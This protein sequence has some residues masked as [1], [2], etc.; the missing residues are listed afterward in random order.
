MDQFCT[1]VNAVS[2]DLQRIARPAQGPQASIEW[3]AFPVIAIFLLKP[4]FDGFMAEA[5]RDHYAIVRKALKT[6]WSKFFA[7]N[8]KLRVAVI[9]SSGERKPRYS[10]VFAIYTFTDTGRL[11]KLLLREDCREDE[12]TESIDAFLD[13]LESYHC[14][15]IQAKQ[16]IDIEEHRTKDG[17]ILVEYDDA[18]KSLRVVSPIP[19]SRD[20][21]NSTD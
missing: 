8:R 20:R 19:S 2:L 4:Y 9:T 18:S 6:L 3:L 1:D 17:V 10:I 21:D 14:G 15:N 13:F 12:Y 11:I 5:G 7:K 16:Q